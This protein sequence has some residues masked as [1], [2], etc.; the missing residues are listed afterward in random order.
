M[1]TL[2]QNPRRK[3]SKEEKKTQL[4]D[5]VVQPPLSSFLKRVL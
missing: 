3:K 4:K 2:N 1:E 5:D